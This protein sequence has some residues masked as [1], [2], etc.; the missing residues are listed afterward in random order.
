MAA[1]REAHEASLVALEDSRLHRQRRNHLIRR[2]HDEGW[3]Y[4]RLAKQIGVSPELIAKIVQ[5][6]QRV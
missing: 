2:L 5:G 6:G 4:G 1:A 3:S